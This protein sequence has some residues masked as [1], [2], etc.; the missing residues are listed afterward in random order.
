MLDY[1]GGPG[2]ITQVLKWGGGRQESRVRGSCDYGRKAQRGSVAGS[3]DAGRSHKLRKA[4]VFR[5][6]RR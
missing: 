6:W 3:G 5:N 1:L 4:A 2:I